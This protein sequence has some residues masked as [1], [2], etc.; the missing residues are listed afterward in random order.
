MKQITL[1]NET[2]EM[3][4]AFLLVQEIDYL[5][6]FIPTVEAESDRVGLTKELEACRDMLM[7]V[8]PDVYEKSE[9]GK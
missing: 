3:T 7:Q 5:K 4:L 2:Y 1:K 9:A 8:S 6:G